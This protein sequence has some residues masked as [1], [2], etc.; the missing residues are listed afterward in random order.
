MVQNNIDLYTI[1]VNGKPQGPYT[2][3]ELTQLNITP[4]TFIKRAGMDDYK[5]AHELEEIR[6]LLG[7]EILK[8]SPQYYASLER[9]FM[10]N[11][12]D[13]FTVFLL[14][15]LIVYVLLLFVNRSEGLSI[16]LYVYPSAVVTF[17]LYN[18]VAEAS[19][20]QGTFGKKLLGIM[21]SDL[22]GDR[23]SVKTSITRNFGK[24]ICNLT[25][26]IGYLVVIFSKRNQGL[27][28]MM[29]DT[30]VIKS[31]LF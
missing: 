7:L 30:L 28:D 22:N 10:A 27:H 12:F 20:M 16:V 9:R 11:L 17:Y 24:L 2:F 26:G 23:I 4:S 13:L 18:I 8:V 21:V 6:E 3:T 25:L 14:H 31:R 15:A 1:I 29:A 5:E 19:K